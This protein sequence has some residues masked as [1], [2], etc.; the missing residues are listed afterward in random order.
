[1][2]LFLLDEDDF[3]VVCQPIIISR[4]ALNLEKFQ[5]F[6]FFKKVLFLDQCY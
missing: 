5:N 3:F 2:I 4:V 1:M 6:K